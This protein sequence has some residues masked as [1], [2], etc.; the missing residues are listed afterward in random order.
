M[1]STQSKSFRPPKDRATV[2]PHETPHGRPSGQASSKSVTASSHPC[3]PKSS[4]SAWSRTASAADK[5]GAVVGLVGAGGVLVC[6]KLKSI[7]GEHKIDPGTPIDQNLVKAILESGTKAEQYENAVKNVLAFCASVAK[8]DLPADAGVS[9]LTWMQLRDRSVSELRKLASNIDKHH[10]NVNITTVTTASV[11]VVAGAIT[12]GGA[13]LAPFTFG[14]SAVVGAAAVGAAAAVEAT[15]RL[16]AFGASLTEMG[17]TKSTYS[18]AQKYIDADAKQTE[19]LYYHIDGLN[20]CAEALRLSTQKLDR[21]D[22]LEVVKTVFVGIGGLGTVASS[23]TPLAEGAMMANHGVRI[24]A[25]QM[26]KVPKA[27][28]AAQFGTRASGKTWSAAMFIA[29]QC[30]S[31]AGKGAWVF[32]AIAGVGIVFDVYTLYTT[33]IDL[34]NGSESAA[35]KALREKAKLLQSEKTQI[36]DLIKELRNSQN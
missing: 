30:P 33:S 34:A 13:I 19:K 35:G 15:A 3:V 28:W 8:I 26:V 18:T 27:Q 20:E 10:M 9:H 29:K 11:A 5:G 21:W 36:A 24:L 17:L 7:L 32:D 23:A 4:K 12:L 16:T 22:S 2:V 6:D 14:V 31:L 25:K 1:N